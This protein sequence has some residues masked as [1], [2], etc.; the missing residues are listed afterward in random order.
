M[1]GLCLLQMVCRSADIPPD[2]MFKMK[3]EI[4][5]KRMEA[6]LLAM[7]EYLRRFM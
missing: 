7:L 3:K 5:F 4:D 1:M 2:A 6:L